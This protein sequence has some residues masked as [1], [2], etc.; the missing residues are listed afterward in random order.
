MHGAEDVERRKRDQFN[1]TLLLVGVAMLALLI[2]ASPF[3]PAPHNP[4]LARL[5]IKTQALSA[6]LIFAPYSKRAFVFDPLF[7][8]LPLLFWVFSILRPNWKSHFA[9][10]AAFSTA[11][12]VPFGAI[13]IYYLLVSRSFFLAPLQHWA[14]RLTCFAGA[15]LYATLAP[16]AARKRRP[17]TVRDLS[18][19]PDAF[20]LEDLSG[21]APLDE[22]TSALLPATSE[23]WPTNVPANRLVLGRYYTPSKQRTNRWLAPFV[24]DLQQTLIVAPPGSGKT[25]SIA[26]PWTRELPHKRQSVFVIDLKGNMLQKLYADW[27]PETEA[28]RRNSGLPPLYYFDP[29]NPA[30]SIHWNPLLELN[31]N[32]AVAFFNGRD[33][34][35]EAIFGELATGD[36]RFFDLRDLRLIKAAIEALFFLG[37]DNPTLAQ[38]HEHFLTEENLDAVITKLNASPHAKNL[39]DLV[40]TLQLPLRSQK[41]S[42]EEILQG[43]HNKLQPF[44]HPAL[45]AVLNDSRDHTGATFSLSLL[46]DDRPQ[47][48]ICAT[49]LELGLLGSTAAS[50]MVRS[51]QQM[52]TKRFKTPPK[53]RLFMVLDEFSKLHLDHKQV[54]EFISTSREAGAVSVIFLQDVSQ[55]HERTRAAVLANCQDKY[56]LRGAGPQTAEWCS[57]ALGDRRRL[58]TSMSESESA[59]AITLSTGLSTSV[60]ES[61]VPVLRSREIATTGGLRYGAWIVLNRYSH[62]PMLVDLERPQA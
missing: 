25:Y 48:F 34:I 36:N 46:N 22:I 37:H 20:D 54:E 59:S 41:N 31:I 51:L 28:K 24:D 52:L 27:T 62:K 35:A 45:K 19:T 40:A 32:D 33:A 4:G 57:R 11:L 21:A 12:T 6:K 56:F 38:A 50:L 10:R 17:Q 18:A 3:V 55:I 7:F 61:W 49:P 26:L 58:N 16:L 53:T 29:S 47:V 14:L 15:A 5:L 9:E 30:A 1:I 44:S 60:T 8:L 2:Y 42:F 39:A 13:L 23:T 43:V